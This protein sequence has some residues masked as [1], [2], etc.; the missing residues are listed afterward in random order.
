[1]KTKLCSHQSLQT[2]KYHALL[3][4]LCVYS[5]ESDYILFLL[6]DKNHY[7]YLEGFYRS[8]GVSQL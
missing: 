4:M 7:Y 1:M 2:Q 5:A 3:I 6:L 8:C